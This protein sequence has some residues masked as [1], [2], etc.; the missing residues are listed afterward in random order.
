MPWTG[1][2]VALSANGKAVAIFTKGDHSEFGVQVSDPI[3][4]PLKWYSPDPFKTKTFLNRPGL[5]FMPDSKAILLTYDDDKNGF[6]P[7]LLPYPAGTKVPQ[8]SQL[9]LPE[10][11]AFKWSWMP[12]DA[13]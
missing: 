6:H 1:A 12:A 10:I 11:E 7:W 9:I 3:G 4:S 13:T 2:Q 8:P 5:E